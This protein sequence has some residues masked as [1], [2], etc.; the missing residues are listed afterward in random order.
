MKTY[1][2]FGVK[3]FSNQLVYRSEVWLRLLG[4]LITI[5]IQTAIWKAVI[6]NSDVTGIN[7]EQMITYSILN[8]LMF[9][10][11]IHHMIIDK[12][13]R[14]L[15]SGGIGAE[16]IK[17]VS[18]P[19]YLLSDS[20]GNAAY[21]L[22]FTVVPSII[23]AWLFFGILPPASG[24][25]LIAF[26]AA[27]LIALVISFLIGYLLS[28]IAFWILNSFALSWTLGGLITIF[29]GSFLPLW[30]FPQS[31]AAVARMLPFQYLGYVPASIYLG[32]TEQESIGSL[33]ILGCGWI[34][35][36]FVITYWLWKRAVS[37][38]II[39]GG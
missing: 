38:L 13:D 23:L 4:N 2:M 12:V 11:L 36:L 1:F 35:V 17:P 8:T 20:I 30:F 27:L 18:Y 32:Y 28:L 14:N 7:V 26:I 39:Q 33:L 25:N 15:K 22:L 5:F 9:S 37:R 24:W 31:W 6:T 19:M 21:Q 29:S 10:V 16:L 34:A 3:S